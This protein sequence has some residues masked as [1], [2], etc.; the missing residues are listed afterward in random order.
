MQ[1]HP[2][3]TTNYSIPDALSLFSGQWLMTWRLQY[4]ISS[5]KIHMIASSQMRW[6]TDENKRCMTIR[7][8]FCEFRLPMIDCF[9]CSGLEM[10][11]SI[12][13]TTVE[14]GS[15]TAKHVHIPDI[16][17]DE[18]KFHLCCH[19]HWPLLILN[20]YWIVEKAIQ[21]KQPVLPTDEG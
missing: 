9:F 18:V 17:F 10:N 12:Y 20:S 16:L 5:L 8:I 15:C 21:Y 13:S 7:S 4:L 3:K 14:E 11:Q 1:N 19:R 2:D 6:F